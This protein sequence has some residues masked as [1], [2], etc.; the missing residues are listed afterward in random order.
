MLAW[1]VV[2]KLY[3]IE[4]V[5]PS[6]VPLMNH[7]WSRKEQQ[8]LYYICLLYN[9]LPCSENESAF[10]V[11]QK[12]KWIA[13][14][15]WGVFVSWGGVQSSHEMWEDSRHKR[16]KWASLCGQSLHHLK[17]LGVELLLFCNEKCL[18]RR[19]IC[20]GCPLED[21]LRGV[22]GH[23]TR[24]LFQSR[25]RTH[26]R[27]PVPSIVWESF[28]IHQKLKRKV[29]IFLLDLLPPSTNHRHR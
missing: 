9:F 5:W 12:K 19:F 6:S 3:Y 20:L 29:W 8:F 22:S 4:A 11:T 15:G 25:P 23:P 26:W 28:G 17:E 7:I 13:S 16:L 2:N 27:D 21:S 24:R 18:L 10:F 14:P 1:F